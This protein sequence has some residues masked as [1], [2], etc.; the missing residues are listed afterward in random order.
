[1]SE[2]TASE[3]R[4]QVTNKIDFGFEVE[5]FIGSRVGQYLISRAEGEITDALEALKEVDPTN[6]EEVRKLQT[7]IKRAESI[8]YWMAE[9]IQEGVNAQKMLTESE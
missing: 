5:A 1:M 8:Q 6:A 2:E 4:R 3:E 9:A 7:T